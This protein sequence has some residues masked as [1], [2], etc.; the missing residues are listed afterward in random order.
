R[1][2]ASAISLPSSSPARGLSSVP[3]RTFSQLPAIR[4][5]KRILLA[6]LDEI[7]YCFAFASPPLLRR[8]GKGCYGTPLRKGF[9]RAQGTPPL[10]GQPRR[11]RRSSG[12]SRRP[13]FG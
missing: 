3:P 12:G 8:I 13:R 2:H 6:G 7:R 10:D 5:R 11:A 9:E 1:P 4:A